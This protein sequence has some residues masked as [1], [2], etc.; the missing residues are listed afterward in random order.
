[1]HIKIEIASRWCAELLIISSPR[2]HYL[3]EDTVDKKRPSVS[4][5]AAPMF[6]ST[7][8]FCLQFGVQTRANAKADMSTVR[9]SPFNKIRVCQTSSLAIIKS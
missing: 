7:R 4:H 9:S 3:G 8:Q 2:G 5:R 6:N 1:M